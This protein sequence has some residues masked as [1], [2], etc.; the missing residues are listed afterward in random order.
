MNQE[1]FVTIPLRNGAQASVGHDGVR[2]G[3]RLFALAD[4]QD[5]RQVAP[6]PETVALRVANERHGVEFQPAHPGDSVLLLEGLFRLRPE[7]RPAGFEAPASLPAGFPPLPPSVDQPATSNPWGMHSTW[8]PH[9]GMYVPPPPAYIPPPLSYGPPPGATGGRLTPFPR[10]R[11]ELI[12]ATFELFVAHWRRWLLLGVVALFL[13]QV[14]PG[15]VDALFHV[16]DGNELWAGVTGAAGGA[17]SG[18]L[19]VSSSSLP[20]GNLLLLTALDLLITSALGAL[21]TGWSAA[22]LGIASRDA[23]FGR[24]PKVGAAI[25]AGLKRLFPAMGASLFSFAFILL[26]LLPIIVLYGVI[27]TQFGSA[28]ADPTTLDP[29]S[30]AANV[31]GVLGCLTLIL[32]IPSF[33]LAIYVGV[34]LAVAPYIAATEPLGPLAAMRKSWSLTR[35]LWWHTV[36]PIFAIAVLARI[37][38]IPAI[39]VQYASFGISALVAIPLVVALTT[40]LEAIVA[41][42]VLYDLR[43][44]REGY[45]SL[46]SEDRTEDETVSTTV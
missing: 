38:L 22:V 23:L 27:L 26:I 37:I 45:A 41:I 21:I 46:A 19:G 36:L 13:P 40:P 16:L 1:P 7:L 15:A 33:I 28:L 35:R 24:A 31:L 18:S 29:S 5:A 20:S 34:R 14:I 17:T 44:R 12:G 32:M 2:V 6:D 10:S 4:I 39:F 3:E 30:A 25:R 43:L 42:V 8:P 11:S 9:P